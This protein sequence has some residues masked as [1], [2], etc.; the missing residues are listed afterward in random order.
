MELVLYP[1]PILRERTSPVETVDEQTRLLARD[2]LDLMQ[3]ERG[4]GLAAPQVGVPLRLFVC[5]LPREEREWVFVNPE[6]T[7]NSRRSI[8]F[9]ESCLSLPGSYAKVRRP[10]WV[11]LAATDLC[12]Q[13]VHLRATGLLARVIQH[14]I[15]HLDGIVF[16]DHLGSKQ[17]ERLLG[18]SQVTETSA[19]EIA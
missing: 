3:A 8:R 10:A 12:G 18:D 6:I 1:A 15:D 17:R 7:G 16:V 5:C 14:E 2:M 19:T 4:I 11:D 9:E 13:A